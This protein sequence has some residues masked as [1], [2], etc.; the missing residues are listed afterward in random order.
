[1]T[2]TQTELTTEQQEANRTPNKFMALSMAGRTMQ[3]KSKAD[4]VKLVEICNE[5]YDL[6]SSPEL[7][8]LSPEAAADYIMKGIDAQNKSPTAD[9]EKLQPYDLVASV[10]SAWA[11]QHQRRIDRKNQTAFLNVVIDF[12]PKGRRTPAERGEEGLADVE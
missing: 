12:L 4:F 6:G 1:M 7:P 8:V 2:D 11:Q 5:S 9:F 10:V 3:V